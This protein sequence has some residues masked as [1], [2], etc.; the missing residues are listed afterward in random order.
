MHG[1]KVLLCLLLAG[2]HR[3][4]QEQQRGPTKVSQTNPPARAAPVYYTGCIT[5]I[6]QWCRLLA[7]HDGHGSIT[8]FTELELIL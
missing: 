1:K 7:Y 3:A 8:Q 6:H 2:E 4:C 5:V